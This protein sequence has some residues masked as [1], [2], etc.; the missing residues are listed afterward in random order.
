MKNENIF[1]LK[2]SSVWLSAPV[3]IS[4]QPW[5]RNAICSVETD[6]CPEDLLM[7]LKNFE[8]DFGRINTKRNEPRILDLDVVAYDDLIMSKGSL[9]I[10]HPRLQERAF[11]LFPLREIAPDWRHPHSHHSVDTLIEN[12]P[13][14]QDLKRMENFSLV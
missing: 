9:T 14:G 11:V 3:P 6:L 2:V 12:I 8:K 13:L 5:Y 4:D 1:V 10:P 7:V